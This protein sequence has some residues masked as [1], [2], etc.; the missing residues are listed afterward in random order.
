LDRQ[1]T[2]VCSTLRLI[3]TSQ[4]IRRRLSKLHGMI[5]IYTRDSY[6]FKENTQHFITS[7]QLLSTLRL[8]ALTAKG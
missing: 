5:E 2:N 7:L 1:I 4:T 6:I 8:S 3:E